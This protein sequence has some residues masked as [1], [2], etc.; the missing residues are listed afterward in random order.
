[1]EEKSNCM[2]RDKV[3]IKEIEDEIRFLKEL[4]SLRKKQRSW[5]N[6]F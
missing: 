2:D 6:F 1:M 4:K 5:Y 3:I